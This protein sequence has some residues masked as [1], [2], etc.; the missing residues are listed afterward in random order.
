MSHN[1]PVHVAV[2]VIKNQQG[3]VL[4][5]KRKKHVHQGD[6]WEFPGGKVEGGENVQQALTRELLEE[7][8]IQI[9]HS[10]PLIKINHDYGDKVVFLD[11]YSID[12]FSGHASGKEQQK[13]KWVNLEELYLYHFPEA[14]KPIIQ[15]T[16]LPDKHMIT[17]HFK[18]ES[19]L[20]KYVQTAIEKGIKLIQFRAHE[21]DEES[22]FYYAKKLFSCCENAAIK[23]MLNR[24]FQSYKKNNAREYSHGLHLTSQELMTYKSEKTSRENILLSA[25]THTVDDLT[26]AMNNKLD[27]ILLSPVNITKTHPESI[28]LGWSKFKQ[29]VNTVNIPVYALGGMTNKDIKLAKENGAQGIAAISEFWNVK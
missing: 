2:G 16:L 17:G 20:I 7:L 23:L 14:N 28:S 26:I 22:Y 13:I 18:N 11:V 3:Q 27:F 25:S 6:L 21:L 8:G 12:Y 5:S 9:T 19:D 15:A 10:T 24:S 29:M 1:K 4:I